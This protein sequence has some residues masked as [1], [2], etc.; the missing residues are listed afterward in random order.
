MPPLR[1]S[2]L[3]AYRRA[4]RREG[5]SA[6]G[7]AMNKRAFKVAGAKV[8]GKVSASGMVSDLQGKVHIKVQALGEGFCQGFCQFRQCCRRS[9][10]AWLMLRSKV[11]AR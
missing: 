2:N 5:F 9:L 6:P 4:Y 10:T 3:A 7:R 1:G 8:A 11:S